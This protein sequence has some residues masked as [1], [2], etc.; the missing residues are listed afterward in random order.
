MSDILIRNYLDAQKILVVI[1]TFNGADY[2]DAPMGRLCNGLENIDLL[3]V[4]NNSDDNT[5]KIIK[6]KY[7]SVRLI[8]NDNNIGFGQAN[9]IGLRYAIEKGYDYVYLLNQDA[10]IE[11]TAI[12]TLVEIAEKHPDYGIISPMQVYAGERKIDKVFSQSLPKELKDDFI[13]HGNLPEDLYNVS[14]RTLQAAHWLLRCDAL[15]K[16]GGFSPTFFHWGEDSNLCRRM[17]F[18][19]CALG[20]A[21]KILAV[22]NRENRNER[23]EKNY[24]LRLVSWLEAISDP[25]RKKSKAIK[26]TLVLMSDCLI[27]RPTWFLPLLFK[28]IKSLPATLKNRKLSMQDNG[29]F[30]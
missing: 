28:F 26:R 12:A 5:A 9:N 23:P 30:L 4:D 16:V 14:G 20:I 29:A 19:G 18:H 10:W 22:H 1:V 27:Y 7:P 11:P 6:E 17:E 8:S 21:P 15:R 24:H 2:I 25:T 13:I 3:V